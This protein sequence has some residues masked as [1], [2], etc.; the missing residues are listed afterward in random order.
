MNFRR[1]RAVFLKEC[2]HILR[3]ARSL[4]M[5]LAMPLLMLLLFGYALTLDVDRIPTLVYD[6]DR[7]SASRELIARFAG[8]ALLRDSR[9]RGQLPA[10]RARRSTA[11]AF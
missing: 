5:A 6:H 11:A 3:D 7:T 8:L 9:L 10:H 4:V 1:T 2:R